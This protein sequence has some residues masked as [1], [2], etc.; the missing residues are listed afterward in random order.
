MAIDR[1]TL[2]SLIEGWAPESARPSHFALGAL[3]R[4]CEAPAPGGSAPTR[5]GGPRVVT[6]D[7]YQIINC[8][9]AGRYGTV[10]SVLSPGGERRALKLFEPHGAG[11]EQEWLTALASEV[12]A[13]VRCRSD[14]VARYERLVVRGADHGAAR[15]ASHLIAYAVRELVEGRP[16]RHGELPNDPLTQLR[17]FHCLAQGLADLHA[18]GIIHGDIRPENAIAQDGLAK[19]IDLGQAVVFGS[20][21]GAS[22]RSAPLNQRPP[23]MPPEIW[24]DGMKGHGQWKKPGDVYSLGAT[25]CRLVTGQWP[26]PRGDLPM[27]DTL[28]RE[29]L[30]EMIGPQPN[31]RPSARRVAQEIEHHAQSARSGDGLAWRPRGFNHERA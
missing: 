17:L 29:L 15:D 4:C 19:W 13:G 22:S 28:P 16:P 18:L 12:S 26:G 7:G 5:G 31:E 20:R 25:F 11:R 27:Q 30:A 21:L 10:F 24:D 2:E 23:T 3:L 6:L 14:Y 9:G 8:L 1:S